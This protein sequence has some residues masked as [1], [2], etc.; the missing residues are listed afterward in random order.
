MEKVHKNFS[1]F[2]FDYT[3]LDKKID[4][5]YKREMVLQKLISYFTIFAIFISVLGLIGLA[6]Y[7][8]KAKGGEIAIRKV[9][10]AKIFN[11][12]SLLFQEYF[13]M[14]LI[15][16]VIAL[17]IAYYF[18]SNWL[19]NFAYRTALGWQLYL[20]PLLLIIIITIISIGY[21]AIKSAIRNPIKS[22]RTE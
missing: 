10:G 1:E 5:A 16:C 6:T 19:A 15:S 17:P 21:S 18:T 2:P 14:I 22:L 8:A 13:I 11:I 4:A 7:T 20:F 12:I 9:L 3:F